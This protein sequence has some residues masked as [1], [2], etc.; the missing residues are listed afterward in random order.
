[1]VGEYSVFDGVQC[2]LGK[3]SSPSFWAPVAVFTKLVMGGDSGAAEVAA[4]WGA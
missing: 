4:F 3:L 2:S 1:M